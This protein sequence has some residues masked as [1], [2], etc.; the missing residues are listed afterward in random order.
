MNN[1]RQI[2]LLD[3]ATA[4]T[5][6]G[7]RIIMDA[8]Q[9]E[10]EEL[11]PHT[12]VQTAAS[13]DYMGAKSRGHIRGS[14]V[15][16]AAGTNLLSSRMWLRAPWKLRPWDAILIDNVVLM[17]CGWYQYQR[18]TDPYSKWLL[19]S[20]LSKAACHSVRLLRYAPPPW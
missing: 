8:I 4:S 11:F 18:A 6:V 15:A 17:G 19:R 5:N 7:D 10:I 2:A 13:H 20:V 14:E 3:T 16:I 12:F 9:N 1:L